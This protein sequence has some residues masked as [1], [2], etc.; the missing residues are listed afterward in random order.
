M[1]APPI[2]QRLAPL[3]WRAPIWLRTSLSLVLASAWPWALFFQ[4]T[5]IQ[6]F[7]FASLFASFALALAWLALSWLRERPP[8]ARRLVVEAFVL[9]SAVMAVAA[10]LF[11]S[12][13]LAFDLGDAWPLMALMLMLGLPVALASGC[14]FAWGALHQPPAPDEQSQVLDDGAF[15]SKQ[16]PF[17]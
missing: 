12:S 5:S 2:P 3:I 13:L 11:M 17:R 4:D 8:K 14:I 1:D 10:P 16:Q 9:A 15:K 6:R 7:A